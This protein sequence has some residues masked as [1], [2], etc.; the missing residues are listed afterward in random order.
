MSTDFT[1][2]GLSIRKKSNIFSN[3]VVL[4]TNYVRLN[5]FKRSMNS[6]Y[7][8]VYLQFSKRDMSAISMV[9]VNFRYASL[10]MPFLR[11]RAR[12]QPRPMRGASI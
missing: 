3:L 1:K 5:S 6:S 10:L 4:V 12:K 2:V 8:C 11:A 9:G 7:W